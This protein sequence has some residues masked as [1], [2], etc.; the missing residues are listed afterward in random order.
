MKND[1]FRKF[2]TLS[3]ENE[4]R[5]KT[6]GTFVAER[7]ESIC[8]VTLSISNIRPNVV[9]C[10][11]LVKVY[12]NTAKFVDI[13][14]F[15]SDDY[16]NVT[17]KQEIYSKTLQNIELDEFDVC[18][19]RINNSSELI[20]PLVG[21]FNDKIKWREYY[22]STKTETVETKKEVV[23]ETKEH[24]HVH[25]EDELENITTK[26]YEFGFNTH[27]PTQ[28]KEDISEPECKKIRNYNLKNNKP[29]TDNKIY[30]KKYTV[31]QR[32]KNIISPIE[33]YD[34]IPSYNPEDSSLTIEKL[35]EEIKKLKN[36]AVA[37]YDNNTKC[38]YEDIQTLPYTIDGIF[39]KSE[40]IVPFRNNNH[41]IEWAI[42]DYTDLVIIDRNLE[43]V[44]NPFIRNSYKKFCH[45][46]LGRCFD[47]DKP[48]YMIGV[49]DFFNHEYEKD[50]RALGFISYKEAIGGLA[51][52]YWLLLL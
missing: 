52:G 30:V 12:E 28:V 1:Y 31:K 16:G 43:F 14:T 26:P 27:K 22:I 24:V 37:S 48:I 41:D 11:T 36:L 34:D 3:H 25:V 2:I 4:Q 23:T 7:R 51:Q 40:K 45:F 15:K 50:I 19:I 5:G 17:L 6:F 18:I 35:K 9:Y 32:E 42:V 49:P 33:E 29:N 13:H 20:T 10:L 46:I 44:K 21:Y 39:E 47:N 38:C 8:K